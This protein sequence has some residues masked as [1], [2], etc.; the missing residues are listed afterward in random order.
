MIRLARILDHIRKSQKLQ[1][2]HIIKFLGINRGIYCGMIEGW[3]NLTPTKLK[4]IC[5]FLQLPIKD[6]QPLYQWLEREKL[7]YTI[8]AIRHFKH[9][10]DNAIQAISDAIYF[11]LEGSQ[12]NSII[13]SQILDKIDALPQELRIAVEEIR[14]NQ[15]RRSKLRDSSP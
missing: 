6:Y 8:K 1:Q 15:D 11:K 14:T 9:L 5:E 3:I 2:Q 13:Y 10:D 7:F 4:L 12:F